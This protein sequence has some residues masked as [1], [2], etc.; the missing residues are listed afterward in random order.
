M[1]GRAN[2]KTY[3]AISVSLLLMRCASAAAAV[4]AQDGWTKP[5][6]HRDHA[7][8]EII[9]KFRASAAEALEEEIRVVRGAAEDP[10]DDLVVLGWIGRRRGGAAGRGEQENAGAEDEEGAQSLAHWVPS[11][12]GRW[13]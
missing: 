7:A 10:H 1:D 2:A 8:G 11:P 4:S 5:G 9:V 12:S 6:I 13:E 3:L